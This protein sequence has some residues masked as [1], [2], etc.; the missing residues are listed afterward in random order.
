MDRFAATIFQLF[1][2]SDTASDTLASLKRLHG[3]M[4]YFVLKGILKVS[5]P[6]AMI[7]GEL[8]VEATYGSCIQAFLTS[9]SLDHLVV[10]LSSSGRYTGLPMTGT[11]GS[12][13]CSHRL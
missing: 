11:N 2:A 1:V 12:V 9:S 4:P 3:L 5:N 13:E 8:V 7:R 6:M 10:N